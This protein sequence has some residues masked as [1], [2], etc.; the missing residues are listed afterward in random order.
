[1]SS[2]TETRTDELKWS[3][4]RSLSITG[5]LTILF[6]LSAIGIFSLAYVILYWSLVSH[7][8]AKENRFI[9]EEVQELRGLLQ[10]LPE[11]H[12]ALQEE[13]KSEEK[14]AGKCYIRLLDEYGLTLIATSGMDK[15][16]GTTCFPRPIGALDKPETP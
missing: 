2:K 10:N 14:R 13:I 4:P 15:A 6:A 7:L 1:M 9:T 3:F 8:Y 16:V 12:E 11:K 5:R